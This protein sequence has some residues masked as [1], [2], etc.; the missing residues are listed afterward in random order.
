MVG[1]PNWK[2]S[3]C[4]QR[5]PRSPR[6]R[7]RSTRSPGGRSPSG[8]HGRSRGRSRMRWPAPWP[9][10]RTHTIWTAT[11]GRRG[12][13][14]YTS[15]SASHGALVAMGWQPRI[16]E[17]LRGA[18]PRRPPAR[19][20]A[21]PSRARPVPRHPRRGRPARSRRWDLD[22]DAAPL[23]SPTRRRSTGSCCRSIRPRRRDLNSCAAAAT[24][25]RPSSVAKSIRCMRSSRAA[26]R[27]T[28][29]RSIA[30]RRR[31]ASTM[32]SHATPS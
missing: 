32:P 5:Q 26:K 12:R 10:L 23:L 29:R 7:R 20:A 9:R 11:A 22:G 16:G 31:R 24:C 17:V 21:L 27:T 28:P 1:S 15:L 6:R 14:T 25:C 19:R 4:G 8:F 18:D 13:S 30:M 2:G 3:S